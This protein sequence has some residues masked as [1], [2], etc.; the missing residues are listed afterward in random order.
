MSSDTLIPQKET[1]LQCDALDTAL[2]ATLLQNGQPVAYAS[3]SLTDTER[4]YAQIEKELLAIVLEQRNLTSTSMVAKLPSRVTTNHLKLSTT[5][6]SW[7]LPSV[8]RECYFA[9]RSTTLALAWPAHV[10]GRHAFHSTPSYHH[11]A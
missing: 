9:C 2:G 7:P 4:N 1:M 6:P 3:Q 11:I 8:C 5:N 10:P